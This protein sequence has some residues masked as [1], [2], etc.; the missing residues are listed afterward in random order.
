MDAVL[1]AFT[2][3]ASGASPVLEFIPFQSIVS[4][5]DY[6]NAAKSGILGDAYGP[7][8]GLTYC[9]QG[10]DKGFDCGPL[11][12]SLGVDAVMLVTIDFGAAVRSN[13]S[14]FVLTAEVSSQLI[15][16]PEVPL[17]TGPSQFE[18]TL[19]INALNHPKLVGSIAAKWVVMLRP[20]ADEYSQIMQI[21]A[22]NHT[23]LPEQIG[24]SLV[25]ALVSEVKKAREA[26]AGTK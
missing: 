15:G 19:D 9:R 21:A 26:G 25:Q 20:N 8:Q 16:P 22:E 6:Q 12:K 3:A 5:E 4:N 13:G 24:T 7:V 11:A 17:S 18:E 14:Q 10:G 2:S 23:K 1:A